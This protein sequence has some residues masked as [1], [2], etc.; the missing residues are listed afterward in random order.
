M[1]G[2]NRLVFDGLDELRAALRRLPDDLTGEA[3]HIVE[4]AANGAAATIGA[5]YAVKS[6][7]LLE[8][9]TVTHAHAGKYGA[10]MVVKN[11]AKHAWLYDNGSE[12]RHY[13]TASGAE[14]ATGKMWGRRPPTHLFVRSVVRARRRMFEQLKAMVTRHGLVVRDGG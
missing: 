7:E 1:A 12:A 10:G 9:L 13:V 11:T 5:G 4:G 14:H 2:G 3:S 6:G 8:G